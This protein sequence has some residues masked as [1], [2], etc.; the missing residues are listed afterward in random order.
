ML[1]INTALVSFENQILMDVTILEAHGRKYD[2]AFMAGGA[3]YFTQAVVQFSKPSFV[4]YK[5]TKKFFEMKKKI[6]GLSFSLAG[7]FEDRSIP[8]S[9]CF[10]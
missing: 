9:A 1:V 3:G 8:N 6:I 5:P 7:S 4:Q 10:T 2:A